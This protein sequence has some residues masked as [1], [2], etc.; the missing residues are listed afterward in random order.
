MRPAVLVGIV[1]L[2]LLPVGQA[3][4]RS[5]SVR[6]VPVVSGLRAPLYV[7][8]PR[9]EPNRLYV[10]EQAGV[11]RVVA[12]GELLRWPFLDIRSRVRSGVGETGT[13]TSSS[14]APAPASDF[15]RAR[16]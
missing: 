11:I 7:T 12:G 14:S 13:S 15:R 1:A 8:A 3:T 16:A 6:L 2:A 10:V 5:T 4:G 9:S